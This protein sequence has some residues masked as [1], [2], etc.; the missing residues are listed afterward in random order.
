MALG[1]FKASGLIWK[2][3]TISA[4][5]YKDGSEILIISVTGSNPRRLTPDECVTLQGTAKPTRERREFQDT[6]S[7]NQAYKT[8]SGE[9]SSNAADSSWKRA[10]TLSRRLN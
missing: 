6:C 5:Y 9:F 7:D 2:E 10:L 4:R 3:R 8:P 1:L